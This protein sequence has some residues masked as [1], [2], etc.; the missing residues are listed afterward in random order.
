MFAYKSQQ[1]PK[2]IILCTGN[3]SNRTDCLYGYH[4]STYAVGTTLIS[5]GKLFKSLS[6]IPTLTSLCLIIIC[7]WLMTSKEFLI[8]LKSMVSK[9]KF[10]CS[11]NVLCTARSNS[12]SWACTLV[13]LL[14][15]LESSDLFPETLSECFERLN[16][17]F[18]CLTKAEISARLSSTL[19]FVV[20]KVDWKAAMVKE[21]K[22]F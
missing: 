17:S 16:F 14:E 7:I 1:K 12:V 2:A 11:E 21:K 15:R 8:S 22:I 13:L 10:L 9:E 20:F 19:N 18:S 4:K 6:C 3:M 5:V